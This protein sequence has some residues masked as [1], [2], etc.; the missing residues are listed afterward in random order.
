M[1]PAA[2]PTA[3]ATTPSTAAFAASTSGRFGIAASVARI[4]PEE[5]S[6]VIMSTPRTPISSRPREIPA[7][8]LLVR[9]AAASSVLTPTATAMP[10]APATV[11]A[12]THQVERRLRTLIHSIR[13]TWEKRYRPL[14]A[15]V[16]VMMSSPW[17]PVPP[18]TGRCRR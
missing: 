2:S 9:S 15:A 17:S 3:S 11:T 5:Y 6:P 18:G 8:A 12:S 13:A 10:T 16:V 7:R 14:V 4:I 1:N